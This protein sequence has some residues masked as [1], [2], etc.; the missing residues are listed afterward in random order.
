MCWKRR[1]LDWPTRCC[2]V[3]APLLPV[4]QP[5]L[6]QLGLLGRKWRPG[7][8]VT[9][10]TPSERMRSIGWRLVTQRGGWRLPPVPRP[11]M[12]LRR[13][14]LVS[15]RVPPLALRLLEVA[16]VRR[17]VVRLGPVAVPPVAPKPALTRPGWRQPPGLV[18]APVRRLVVVV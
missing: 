16:P 4:A 15:G 6:K 11:A 12:A 14:M 17:L 7:A 13:L 10:R 2:L 5:R 8:S 1:P 3:A 18:V 9:S